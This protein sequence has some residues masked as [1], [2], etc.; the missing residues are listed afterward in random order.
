LRH[1]NADRRLTPLGRRV[2]LV[3]DEAWDRLQQKEQTMAT[4]TEQLRSRR[5]GQDTL[6]RILRRTEID[7]NQ[8][9][10]LEPMLRAFDASPAA[11]E[12]VVLEAKYSGYIDRQ[13]AQVERFQRL[14][15]RPIPS[16]FDYMAV[17]QLRAEAKEKLTRIRPTNLGQAGRISGIN[18]ADL[19]V[20]LMYLRSS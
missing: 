12:Q 6:E 19:A 7:W 9:C 10:E 18:P 17:P 14:E 4:L 11:V 16:H 20:V 13:A 2:G 1:D 5:H 15:S 8:V 3:T